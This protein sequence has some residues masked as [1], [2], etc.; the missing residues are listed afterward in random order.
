MIYDD[1]TRRPR[2]H[3]IRST[4]MA[5]SERPEQLTELIYRLI[6]DRYAEDRT[7]GLQQ[8]YVW[9]RDTFNRHDVTH[10]MIAW[11]LQRESKNAQPGVFS[12]DQQPDP[13]S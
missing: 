3:V 1:D 10:E 5:P 8:I 6:A 7:R 2:H 13:T 11:V 4:D 12:P 9:I